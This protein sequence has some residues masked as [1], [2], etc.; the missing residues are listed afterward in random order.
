[1]AKN[2][3]AKTQASKGASAKESGKP[4]SLTIAQRGIRTSHD[5]AGFMSGLMSDLIE[6]N[7]TPSIGNAAC[8][9]GGKLLKVVE[10]QYKYGTAGKDG[11][12]KTLMLAIENPKLLPEG[13][14]SSEG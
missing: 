14:T 1:M 4:R 7:V 12:P 8:N 2:Q 5:F 11:T 13:A 9:A 10:M 3:Q 6:G